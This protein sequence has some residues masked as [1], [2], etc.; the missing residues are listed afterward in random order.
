MTTPT[1]PVDAPFYVTREMSLQGRAY[2]IHHCCG[3]RYI[4]VQQLL[5][6]RQRI[7]RETTR[8]AENLCRDTY[9]RQGMSSRTLPCRAEYVREVCTCGAGQP[10][11]SACVEWRRWFGGYPSVPALQRAN[12]REGI[13]RK[14]M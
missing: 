9:A 5:R 1:A 6:H 13:L 10:E 14:H 11:C 8:E 2:Y 7:H 4:N 3:K 12:A